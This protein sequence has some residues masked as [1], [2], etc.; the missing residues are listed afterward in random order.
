MAISLKKGGRV[1]LSKEAPGLNE[2]SAGLGWGQ[3]ATD[4]KD[5][6][7]DAAVFLLNDEGKCSGEDD[8]I[9]YNH[10]TAFDGAI[11]H[12]GD[13]KTG[14]GEGDDEI[15]V[16]KLANLVANAP[17]IKK[18]AFVVT[19]HEAKE[20]GQSFGQVEDAYIRVVN[21]ADSK[22]LAKFDLSEDYSNETAMIMGELYLKDGEWKM[23]AVGAGFEGGLDAA[24]VKYGL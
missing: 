16:I 24:M 15:I 14:A 13:N 9:F 19:I 12:Q 3:R 7:L 8:F 23:S 22:E 4:G 11:V 20:R 5:F 6:D 2:I 1:N 21:N 18:M 17:H 10:K